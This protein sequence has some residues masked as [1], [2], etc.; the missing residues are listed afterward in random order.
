ME[1]TPRASRIYY[2][3]AT[4]TLVPGSA[5]FHGHPKNVYLPEAAVLVSL[6]A[7]LGE[8]FDPDKIDQ[9]V[10][11]LVASQEETSG[12]PKTREAIKKG[13]LRRAKT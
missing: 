8:L 7:W 4:R 5:A 2:R 6:N 10:T 12:V 9:T 11:A 3:C 13:L 1:A